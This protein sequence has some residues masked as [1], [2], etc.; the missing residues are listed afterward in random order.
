[1]EKIML[2]QVL[3]KICVEEASAITAAPMPKLS[4]GHKRQMKKIFSKYQKCLYTGRK[5]RITGVKRLI[6]V[7]TIIFLAMFTAAAGAASIYGFK[8]N[9]H[10]NYTELL[11]VN[12]ENCPKTIENVYYLSEIPEGYELYEVDSNSRYVY[13]SYMNYNTNR[14]LTFTQN[15]K[16]GYNGNFNTEQQ[17]F[18]GLDINGR[19]ALYLDFSNLEQAG[20]TVVWDNVDYILQISG[21]FTKDELVNLAKSA[22]L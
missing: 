12:S 18:E 8:Q 4:Y 17:N 16:D 7:V 15:V 21:D 22:K 13:T 5:Y 14:C 6:L 9:K 20:G 3:E 19:Y 1:M 11:T 10:H 2:S